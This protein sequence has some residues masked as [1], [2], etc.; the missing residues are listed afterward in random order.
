L[1]TNLWLPLRKWEKKVEFFCFLFAK[2]ELKMKLTEKEEIGKKIK[3][4]FFNKSEEQEDG[5]WV[6]GLVGAG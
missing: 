4:C 1:C 6:N 3:A 2:T 5:W